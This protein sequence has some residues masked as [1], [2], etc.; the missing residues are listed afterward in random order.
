MASARCL[1]RH[2]WPSEN[3]ANYQDY[4]L[5]SGYPH[6]AIVC[7][8]SGCK[9]SAVLW[10]TDQEV[11]AFNRGQRIFTIGNGDLKVRIKSVSRIASRLTFTEI[12]AR[13]LRLQNAKFTLPDGVPFTYSVAG[14]ILQPDCRTGISKEHIKTKWSLYKKGMVE[15]VREAFP[16]RKFIYAILSDPRVG[17]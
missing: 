3:S 2:G 10:L 14:K 16:N 1:R 15:W 7:G 11:S 13:I 17:G 9:S 6:T 12:W 8:A 4:V 5:P